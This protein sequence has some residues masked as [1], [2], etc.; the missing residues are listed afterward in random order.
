LD[1][2]VADANTTKVGSVD[3]Q[4]ITGPT[5]E[6]LYLLVKRV[7]P[8]THAEVAGV[9]VTLTEHDVLPSLPKAGTAAFDFDV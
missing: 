8:D 7:Q 6:P 5:D 1:I 9:T 4:D 3:I 2:E